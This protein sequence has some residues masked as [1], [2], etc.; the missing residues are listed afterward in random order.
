MKSATDLKTQSAYALSDRKCTSYRTCGSIKGGEESISSSIDFATAEF[1]QLVADHALKAFEQGTPLSVTK[2]SRS[3]GRTDDI[4]EQYRGE[5]P[6]WVRAAAN[7][8]H[9]L[10]DFV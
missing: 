1:G 2:R 4:D 10:L 6:V 7:A 9:E 5:K 3:I 8:G